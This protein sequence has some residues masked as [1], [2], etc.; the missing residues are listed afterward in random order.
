LTNILHLYVL[1]DNYNIENEK[2]K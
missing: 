2:N 1:D